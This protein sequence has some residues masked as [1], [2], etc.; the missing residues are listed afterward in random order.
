VNWDEAIEQ[1][2]QS[3]DRMVLLLSSSSMPFRK[4]VHREWFDFDQDG[5]PIHPL[6]I[7]DCQL[8]SRL[9]SYRKL[10]YG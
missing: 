3:C 6:Y 10:P 7:E 1:G 4:E 5:K 2:L 8:Y 9:R